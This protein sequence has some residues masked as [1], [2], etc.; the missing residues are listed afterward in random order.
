MKCGRVVTL[1]GGPTGATNTT[2]GLS[3]RALPTTDG[4]GWGGDHGLMVA[5]SKD[6]SA[7]QNARSLA[8]PLPIARTF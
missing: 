7:V 3:P 8:P 6:G 4:A 1:L 5:T 2:F